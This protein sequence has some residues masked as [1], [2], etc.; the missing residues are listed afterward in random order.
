VSGHD[1]NAAVEAAARD[2]FSVAVVAGEGIADMD[3]YRRDAL[4]VLTAAAPMFDAQVR[5]QV[6]RDIEARALEAADDAAT[7][8]PYSPRTARLEQFGMRVATRALA[9]SARI[10]RGESA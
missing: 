2:L 5:E 10:A 6:A 7:G 3:V 8:T 1:L 9:L 4:T